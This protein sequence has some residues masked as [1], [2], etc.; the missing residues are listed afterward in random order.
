MLGEEATL[1]K[2]EPV[3]ANN[4]RLFCQPYDLIP[5]VS[6]TNGDLTDVVDDSLEW[7]KSINQSTTVDMALP[8]NVHEYEDDE[9]YYTL[10]LV[11]Q[12]QIP[13]TVTLNQK[14]VNNAGIEFTDTD[15]AGSKLIF[16]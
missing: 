9:Y 15:D 7:V 10:S 8:M 6:A 14:I 1:T 4:G 2:S 11:A 5:M 12:S 13:R 3:S 16:Y